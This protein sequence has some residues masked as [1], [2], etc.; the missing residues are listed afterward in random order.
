MAVAAVTAMAFLQAQFS[1]ETLGIAPWAWLG[2][3]VLACELDADPAQLLRPP[4]FA[5]RLSYVVA[6]ARKATRRFRRGAV[7]LAAVL[8]VIVLARQI[9]AEWGLYQMSGWLSAAATTRS[10]AVENAMLLPRMREQSN[11]ILAARSGDA[12]TA[13]LLYRA[14]LSRNDEQGALQVAAHLLMVAPRNPGILINAANLATQK[15]NDKLAHELAVDLTDLGPSHPGFWAYRAA[16][17]ARNTDLADAR[18]SY[19]I[20]D[21]LGKALRDPDSLG[22]ELMKR[23]ARE[24]LRTVPSP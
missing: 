15:F 19:R 11:V 24:F 3:A 7:A 5:R 13:I 10:S 22:Y 8:V 20:A 16:A 1:P 9:R 12:P 23:Q 2:I 4:L 6:I 18:Q 14:L 21:S 17:A